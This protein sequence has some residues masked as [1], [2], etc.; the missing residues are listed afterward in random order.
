MNIRLPYKSL[1]QFEMHDLDIN[2]YLYV[3]LSFCMSISVCLSDV[4]VVEVT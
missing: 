1:I 3:C 4:S 2:I